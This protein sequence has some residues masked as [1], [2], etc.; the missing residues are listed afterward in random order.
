VKNYQ[1]HY[2]ECPV[3]LS[4]FEGT[5]VESIA[6]QRRFDGRIDALVKRAEWLKR[7]GAKLYK[8][9]ADKNV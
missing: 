7:V 1:P 6:R 3:C 5:R 8:P 4:E 2:V 9:G